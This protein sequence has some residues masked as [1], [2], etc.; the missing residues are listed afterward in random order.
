MYDDNYK[1]KHYYLCSDNY[2]SKESNDLLN[3]LNNENILNNAYFIFY[4]KVPNLFSSNSKYVSEEY[5]TK[6]IKVYNNN[7]YENVSKYI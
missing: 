6:Q 3:I 2:I 4:S 1:F 5:I 7:I